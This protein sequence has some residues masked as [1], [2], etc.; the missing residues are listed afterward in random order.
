MSID[1]VTRRLPRHVWVR[2]VLGWMPGC[3]RGHAWL[4]TDIIRRDAW[5]LGPFG[6]VITR[7]P[8]RGTP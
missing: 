8:E 7:M 6:I 3:E 2:F 4:Y 1:L 5:T